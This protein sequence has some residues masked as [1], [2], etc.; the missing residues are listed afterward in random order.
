MLTSYSTPGVYVQ[1]IPTLAPSVA[2]V[3][4]AIPVFIGYT[5]KGPKQTPT[6]I[7]TL[8]DYE[9]IFGGPKPSAFSATINYTP[10][11]NFNPSQSL[12]ISGAISRDDAS[13]NKFL[14]YYGLS[15]YFQ[16]GGGS[17]YILSVGN[18]NNSL[19]KKDFTDALSVLIKRN[20][21]LR[22]LLRVKS[23]I[24]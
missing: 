11:T 19:D 17:C 20:P 12:P 18:Y 2:Q 15:L 16:N 13:T 7:D 3:A 22:S 24:C 4:T 14:M 1:E 10:V 21:V 9:N 5:E 6:R 8:L 23:V